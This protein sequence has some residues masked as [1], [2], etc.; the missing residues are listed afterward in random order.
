M[1][2]T[3]SGL[4]VLV[5][6][7]PTAP[8]TAIYLWV[9]AGA[10]H[11]LPEQRGAAHFVE[12]MLFKGTPD[13][14]VGQ[15]AVEVEGVGGDINAYT[16]HEHTVVH[17][18]V[19]AESWS[20]VL[21]VL[22]DMT[23]RPVFDPEHVEL[24]RDVVLDEIRG[25]D[26]DAARC[27]AELVSSMVF[28]EH[29]Y[30][31]SVIGTASELKR[32]TRDDAM[33][34][35]S[36]WYRPTNM[37]LSVAGPVDEAEVLALAETLFPERGPR[38]DRP[39][40]P[41]EPVQERR[42][43]RVLRDRFD[44]PLVELAWRA[45]AHDHPDAVPL[46]L[47][48]G[49]LAGSASSVLGERLMLTGLATDTWC[50]CETDRD[51]GAVVVGF[52]PLRGKV[53]AC[54]REASQVL[55]EVAAGHHLGIE[56]LQRSRMQLLSSR[57]FMGETVDG[58]AHSRAWYQSFFGDPEADRQYRADVEACRM[59]DVRRVAAS[60]FRKKGQ[61]AGALLPN[62]ELEGSA[63]RSALA[64]GKAPRPTARPA[65]ERVV[66]DSGLTVIVEPLEDAGVVAVRACGLGGALAETRSTSG[67][68][69]LWA[70]AVGAPGRDAGALASFLDGRGGS[71]GGVAGMNSFGLRSEFPAERVDEALELVCSML[72]DPS[73]P[74]DEVAVAKAEL[75]EA[76]DLV[77]DDPSALAWQEAA[78]LL[79]GEHPYG[80]PDGGTRAALARMGRATA[81]RYHRHLV[82]ADNL[83][84]SVAGGVGVDA[85]VGRIDA[86]LGD[87]PSG[88]T[89]LAPRPDPV[90]PQGGVQKR[91]ASDREQ[92]AI[93]IAW[94]GTRFFDPDT[95]ALS[96]AAQ[97]L[98]GQGGRLFLEL[99]DRRGLAYSV[100]ADCSEGWDRGSFSVGMG[101]DPERVDD[102]VAGLHEVV[103]RLA[104]EGPT[105][106]ELQRVKRV[107]VG[108]M[109]MSRQRTSSRAMELAYWERYGRDARTAREQVVERFLAVTSDQ[110]RDA[111]ARHLV[112]PV[113]VVVA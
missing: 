85:V 42:R 112:S 55:A 95:E 40:R 86:L 39:P 25:G 9:D 64:S 60:I 89:L 80:L 66:L 2:H 92:A 1:A 69:S 94:P 17:A 15:V 19:P 102:G 36:T 99:R 41:V 83:V 27:L 51:D 46:D 106:A 100:H 12:H 73:F 62:G 81:L 30:G 59:R 75:A 22:A 44:E 35:H 97:V 16:G 77:S 43:S 56:R 28:R 111:L 29:P 105:A 88:P 90:F 23:L 7:V 53:D 57:L 82:Q 87:L 61:V 103:A 79:F 6:T 91:I 49:M 32:L 101:T 20:G 98:G 110:I 68:T 13:R 65:I 109:A 4:Q 48:V 84:I 71:L 70:R 14:P 50:A 3:T 96:L 107:M 5:D 34:F 63:F 10:A 47:L 33:A 18:T 93:A 67:L 76:V 8:V 26:D 58:R 21:D 31:R 24:E 52:S 45:V 37:I 104:D 113:E 72:A 78:R 74:A 11:E 38:P 54:V 108:G